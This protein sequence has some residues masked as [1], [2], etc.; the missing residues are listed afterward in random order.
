M[1]ILVMESGSFKTF[2][3]AAK[4]T[5]DMYRYLKRQK[6]YDVEVFADYSRIDPD[7]KS[8]AAEKLG[9][10]YDIVMINSIRDVPFI[11]KYIIGKGR[12]PKFIYTDRGNVLLN[13][14]N[15]GIKKLLPKMLL[16]Q[17]FMHEMRKW[18]DCYVAIS[19][20]Q[21][22][23]ARM[24]FGKRTRIEYVPIAPNKVFKNTGERR[25][26]EGAIYVGRL[27]ERQKK[28]SFLIRGMERARKL[29]GLDGK[30][31]ISIIG[32]GPHEERY[33]KL[34]SDFALEGNVRFEGYVDEERLVRIYNTAPF[35]VS[36]SE[37]EGMSRTFVEAMACGLPLLVN[38]KNDTVVSYRPRRHIVKDGY[39]GLVYEYGNLE[40]FARKFIRLYK[41]SDLRKRLSKNAL[42]YSKDFDADRNMESYMRIINGLRYKR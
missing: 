3:G 37:W 5:Y 36:A 33:R 15:S 24:F 17:H 20:E 2:G 8:V 23:N 12:Q 14:S 4:A 41:D 19:A 9:G 25:S 26:M 21:C 1:K 34:V 13:F 22:E 6:G 29:G 42:S 38:T 16:R 31:L 32:T 11:S 30:R 39:N 40:D 10:G 28:V 35:F 7:V 27:D 18:L